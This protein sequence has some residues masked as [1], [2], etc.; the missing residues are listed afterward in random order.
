MRHISTLADPAPTAHSIPAWGEAPCWAT[1]NARGLKARPIAPSIPHIPL[2]AFNSILL[3]ER[4]KL[5]LKITLPV[6]RFLT[7]DVLDQGLQVRRPNRERAISSLPHELR[8]RGR[9]R[10]DPLGRGQFEVLHQLRHR[11]CA[12]QSNRQMDVI[13]NSA[14]PKTFT[15]GIAND[16]GKISI[17]SRTNRLVDPRHSVFRAEDHMDEKKRERLWHRSDYKS[18]LQPSVRSTANFLGL[19]PRLVYP[20]PSALI[21][22]NMVSERQKCSTPS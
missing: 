14:N 5:L 18:G 19:R 15:L 22:P 9:L 11:R 1:P 8:Q 21:Q 17:K 16:S 10:L 6:M 2:V 3:Q 12:R 4:A 20:A 7:L 13:G